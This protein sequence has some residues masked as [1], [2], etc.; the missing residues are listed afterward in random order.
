M[1]RGGAVLE[2]RKGNVSCHSLDTQGQII[3]GYFSGHHLCRVSLQG[4]DGQQHVL[5]LTTLVQVGH[6]AASSDTLVTDEHPWHLH[7]RGQR[8]WK[9]SVSISGAC[10]Q[11]ISWIAISHRPR[12]V[13][14]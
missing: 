5:Q 13:S 6:V 14:M 1:T 7:A 3:L 2:P 11:I 12:P 10:S 9:R 8:S 4:S